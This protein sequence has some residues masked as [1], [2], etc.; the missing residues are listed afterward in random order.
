LQFP[1]LLALKHHAPSSSSARPLD[2]LL[3]EYAA[4]SLPCALHALIGSHLDLNPQS[5]RFVTDLEALG[6]AEIERQTPL[7]SASH[8]AMLDAIFS[9]DT[10]GCGAFDDIAADDV[11]TAGLRRFIGLP[12]DEIP[13]RTVLPGVKE[14]VVADGHGTEAKLYWIKAGRKMPAHTHGGQEVTIVL[15]GAFSDAAGRYKRGDVALADEEIDHKP[16]AD[17]DQD[18]ICFAVTDAPLKLTG[19]VG[20]VIQGLFRN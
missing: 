16:V 1:G 10:M 13:W 5:E 2:A 4:G 9:Q 20:R 19:P 18:C 3:A 8:S 7:A 15:K 17:S 11:F 14:Y 6:G 12:S